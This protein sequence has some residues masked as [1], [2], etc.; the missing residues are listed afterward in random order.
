M[1]LINK[2]ESAFLVALPLAFIWVLFFV[3]LPASAGDKPVVLNFPKPAIGRYCIIRTA[4]DPMDDT[5]VRRDDWATGRITVPPGCLMSLTLNYNGGQNTKFLRTLPPGTLRG[6]VCR[7]LEIDDKA[8]ADMCTQKGLVILNLQGV[9]LTD[10]GA[11]HLSPLKELRKL[12][13]CDTLV[14]PK[15]L[16][17]LRNMPLLHNLNLSRLALGEAVDKPLEPLKN[18]FLLELTGTQLTDKAV[19]EL[20][21]FPKLQSLVLRRNNL[22]DK[23]IDSLRK[24]K[25]LRSLDLT[26]TNV[27]IEG[28]KRLKALPKL[29]DVTVRMRDIKTADRAQLKKLMPRVEIHDGSREQVVPTEIFAPLH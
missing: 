17:V 28:L 8:I 14:S 24:Y 1:K 13:L 4:R 22:T 12:S 20:P 10:Q 9:D 25:T 6:L 23:C 2:A 5:I 11:K 15:G 3:T 19:I 21:F 29:R 7:D 27:T 26:D 18:L 16:A